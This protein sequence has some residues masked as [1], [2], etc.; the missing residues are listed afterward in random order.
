M[1]LQTALD[2]PDWLK[3]SGSIRPR[4]ETLANQF[5]AGRTGDD[6]LLGVQS[7]LK[8]EV[9]TGAIVIGGELLDARRLVGDDGGAAPARST[10]SN[11]CSSILPGARRTSS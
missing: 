4:Y 6:E 8:V 10:R 11:R 7:L 9:D 5:I 1:R 2:L 3:V